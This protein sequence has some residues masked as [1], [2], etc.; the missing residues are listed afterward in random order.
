M[1]F[2]VI[3]IGESSITRQCDRSGLSSITLSTVVLVAVALM[4][5][6]ALINISGFGFPLVTMSPVMV[7]CFGNN[8]KIS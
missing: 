6:A 3:P 4:E 2:T 7:E 1:C 5:M 8:L